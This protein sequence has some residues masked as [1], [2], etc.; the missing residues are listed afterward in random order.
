M[1]KLLMTASSWGHI[2]S[3]H[4][5]YL[6]EFHRL[7]WQV[8]L[9][10]ANPPEKVEGVAQIFNLPFQKKM[11]A[12][13]NLK[14]AAQLRKNIAREGYDLIIC[15]TS[16]A[17]FFTRLAVVGLPRRP[18]VI[19][20][21]HGYLFDDDTPTLKKIIYLG[22]EKVTAPVTDLILTMNH[23]DTDIAQRYHLARE[24]KFVPGIGV[25]L[26][27][28]D[29]WRRD[30]SL[31]RQLGVGEEDI[32]LIYPAEFSKRKNQKFLITALSE[33]P[34]HI[35]LVLP[36]KGLLLEDCKVLSQTLDLDNRVHFPG[37]VADLPRWYGI[38]D[39]A[40]TV[41]HSEGLPFNVMEGMASALPVVASRVKGHTD[42]IV[43]GESGLLFAPNN[44]EDCV[45]Q[46]SKLIASPVQRRAMGECG[47]R[48]VQQYG[49]E[50]V[51]PQ[52]MSA[53][54]QGETDVALYVAC[55]RAFS[56]PAH[57]LLCPIQ[58]GASVAKSRFPGFL[59]D[60]TGEHISLQNPR[61]CEL[62]AQ[63]WAWK[64]DEKSD[65]LGFFHY[66]RF[67]YPDVS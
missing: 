32:L 36:G 9:G 28:Y 23:W 24:I 53:Y 35:H 6:A 55:H 48:A 14:I 66:R 54:G 62:T 16:L 49:L 50:Q 30:D 46:L 25:P 58:V 19:N 42:L 65:Y 7:G 64:N 41:S 40:V 44:L 12:P 52:V 8:H 10:C 3:F 1:K 45:A 18:R 15:H 11:T 20:M 37:F 38:A 67:L 61:Y 4:L 43:E 22:A 33:L 57:R 34:E 27:K 13:E 2:Q 17:V 59:Q 60:D 29:G 63:Y 39:I 21:V 31:R 56:L 51:R 26:S 5:P 47:Q